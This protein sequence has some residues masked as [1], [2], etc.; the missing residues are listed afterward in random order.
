[1][2]KLWGFGQPGPLGVSLPMEWVSFEVP[3]NPNHSVI[4]CSVIS[5]RALVPY[6]GRKAHAFPADWALVL[7]PF[8]GAGPKAVSVMERWGEPPL[9]TTWTKWSNPINWGLLFGISLT[10][11][12]FHQQI[13]AAEA[14]ITGC[15]YHHC[16]YLMWVFRCW[17]LCSSDTM[18]ASAWRPKGRWAE[19]FPCPHS[20]LQLP[21]QAEVALITGIKV[22]HNGFSEW[23]TLLCWL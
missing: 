17:E 9:C 18:G 20:C 7:N 1:M 21:L 13:L 16:R 5:C 14:G 19:R 12:P 6:G 11:P 23:N 8:H 2:V 15:C 3:S 4:L 10:L 22:T